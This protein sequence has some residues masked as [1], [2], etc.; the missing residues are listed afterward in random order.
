MKTR[1]LTI[2]A[3]CLIFT[4]VGLLGSGSFSVV[5]ENSA[6]AQEPYKPTVGPNLVEPVVIPQHVIY[7][8]LF[9]HIETL[10]EQDRKDSL[11]D[12]GQQS[13]NHS[14]VDSFYQNEVNLSAVNSSELDRIAD[15]CNKCAGYT[16]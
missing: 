13:S 5:F 6:S 3:A 16:G 1:N 8:Q 2:I 14:W 11:A 15:E 7:G 9:R 12:S 4:V 10:K